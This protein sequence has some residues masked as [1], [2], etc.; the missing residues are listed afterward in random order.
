MNTRDPADALQV[1]KWAAAVA[2]FAPLI[3]ALLRS[4]R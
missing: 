4:R 3:L 2:L 1:L